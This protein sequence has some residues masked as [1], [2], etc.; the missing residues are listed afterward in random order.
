MANTI[1]EIVI[2]FAKT[3]GKSA[4]TLFL[5]HNVSCIFLLTGLPHKWERDH[6]LNH[7]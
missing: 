6:F 7:F 1:G 3:G 5:Q 4:T 2:Q